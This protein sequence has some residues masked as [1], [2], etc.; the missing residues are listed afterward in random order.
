MRLLLLALLA[1]A[2]SPAAPAPL[3][4]A[5]EKFVRP[6]AG[7]VDFRQEYHR[8]LQVQNVSALLWKMRLPFLT[9]FPPT[10]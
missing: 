4:A 2:P 8:A 1:P 3:P 6:P 9:R 5:L 10:R 7:A